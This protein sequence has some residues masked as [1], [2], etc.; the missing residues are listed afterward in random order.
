M[1]TSTT[2]KNTQPDKYSLWIVPKG[3]A[4][5]QLQQLVNKLATEHAAPHFV[6]HITLVANIY[7][8]SDQEYITIKNNVAKLSKSLQPFT[9]SLS[10]F[11]YT[12]EEFRCLFLRAQPSADIDHVYSATTNFFPQVA[13]EH[14]QTLPHM[15]VLYGS[16]PSDLKQ[17]IISEHQ[18]ILQNEI[19]FHVESFDLYLTNNPIDSW[20]LDSPYK[21]AS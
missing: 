19:T 5:E 8:S 7:A 2:V 16:Y 1:I 6:P 11:E 9:I 10:N 17:K 21:L 14:F 3:K 12:D 13:N 15:S 18:V 4:G 20:T